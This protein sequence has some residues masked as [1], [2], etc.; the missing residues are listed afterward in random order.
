MNSSASSIEQPRSETGRQ[1]ALAVRD[2]VADLEAGGIRIVQIDEPALREGLPSRKSGWPGCLKWSVEAFRLSASGVKVETQ[3]RT[4]MCYCEFNDIINSIAALDA[5]VISIEASLSRMELLRTFSAF[6]YPNDIGPGVWEI[7]SPRVSP[8][9]EMLQ[10][11]RA[12]LNVIPL[13]HLW[14]N[15]DC[16]LKTR[17]WE[18]VLPALQNLVAAADLARGPRECVP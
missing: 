3:I 17:R 8:M 12:A 6:H 2:E 14:V 18:E 9:D 5:D 16:G 4:H 7:H 15:L 13:E 10:L 11:I 1:L